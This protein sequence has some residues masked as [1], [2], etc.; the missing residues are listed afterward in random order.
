MRANRAHIPARPVAL[1]LAERGGSDAKRL[2][3]TGT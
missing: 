1:R 3:V 2:D